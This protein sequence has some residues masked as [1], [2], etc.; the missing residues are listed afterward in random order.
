MGIRW[1]AKDDWTLA[2]MI[3]IGLSRKWIA[4]HLRRSPEA[5]YQRV[6]LLR[7]K[8]HPIPR[9]PRMGRQWQKGRSRPYPQA[10]P[11]EGTQRPS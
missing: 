6:S 10:F 11:V 9:Q 4:R 8:G 2:A 1:S 3:Q 7:R 5:V